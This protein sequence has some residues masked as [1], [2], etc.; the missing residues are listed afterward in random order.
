MEYSLLSRKNR[1]VL[2]LNEP[3]VWTVMG[4]FATAL[5]GMLGFLLTGLI[6]IMKAE[7]AVVNTRIDHLDRDIQFLMKRE[8]G[9]N[10][11]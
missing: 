5:F 9:E 3:Q 8:F 6:R 10:R 7:F 4:V 11:S 2:T 1:K